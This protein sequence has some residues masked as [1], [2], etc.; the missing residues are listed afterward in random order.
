MDPQVSQR[1]NSVAVNIDLA[2][3]SKHFNLVLAIVA[4]IARG[5]E[6]AC[7]LKDF[8]HINTQ[9]VSS[10]ELRASAVLNNLHGNL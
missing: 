8:T 1:T 9:Q 6:A 3:A 10:D 5:R 7:N 4:A 2:Q